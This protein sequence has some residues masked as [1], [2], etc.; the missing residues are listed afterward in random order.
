MDPGFGFTSNITIP[1]VWDQVVVNSL[2]PSKPRFT[3]VILPASIFQQ[4]YAFDATPFQGSFT[5][6]DTSTKTAVGAYGYAITAVS[7]PLYGL[8]RFSGNTTTTA[9]FDKLLLDS[10]VFTV[11]NTAIGTTRGLTT[12]RR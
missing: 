10:Y 4:F 7:D 12:P 5:L 3:V 8:T 6:N 1:L 2:A 9:I 11:N